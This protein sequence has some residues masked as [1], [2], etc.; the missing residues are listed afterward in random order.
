MTE[1]ERLIRCDI[2]RGLFL[3]SMLD[4][5]DNSTRHRTQLY[6]LTKAL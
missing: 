6:K 4:H 2:C 1:I 5:Y 3:P